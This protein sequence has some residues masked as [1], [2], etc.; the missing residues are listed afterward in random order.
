MAK[1]GKFDEAAQY[2][3][4]TAVAF[5]KSNER[6]AQS[7]RS[8][9]LHHYSVRNPDHSKLKGFM[10][11]QEAGMVVEP[12]LGIRRRTAGTGNQLW[13]QFCGQIRRRRKK[14]RKPLLVGTIRFFIPEDDALR[15]RLFALQ[16]LFE[17]DPE[18]HSAKLASQ[19]KSSEVT[20]SE[21]GLLCKGDRT[22][23]QA[24]IRFRL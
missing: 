17:K 5:R 10:W 6:A 14:V 21:G 7:A 24:A 8:A 22:G 11:K 9:V 23:C 2:Q 3:W 16:L 13:T 1:L 20:L 19:L 4:R 12:R 15:I 18:A